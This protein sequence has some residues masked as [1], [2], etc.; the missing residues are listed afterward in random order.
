MYD[1]NSCLSMLIIGIYFAHY[2]K[3]ANKKFWFWLNNILLIN[4]DDTSRTSELGYSRSY[5]NDEKE[6]INLGRLGFIKFWYIWAPLTQSQGFWL[7][8]E[9]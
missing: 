2:I 9:S 8:V 4:E 5:E 7:Q 6:R 3:I 1:N